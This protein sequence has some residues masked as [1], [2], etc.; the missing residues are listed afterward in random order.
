MS[1]FSL[2]VAMLLV[3]VPLSGKGNEPIAIQPGER[4]NYRV[5]W[6]I[7]FHAGEITIIA[8]PETNDNRPSTAVTST[9]STRGVLRR[10][11]RFEAQADA[12]FDNETGKMLVYTEKS[13]G[14]RKTTNY[15]IEFDYP[16]HVARYTDFVQSENSSAI[17]LPAEAPYDLIMALISTRGWNLKPG[18]AR[19]VN[20]LFGKDLYELTVH[21]LRYEDLTTALGTYHT[22]VYEPRM[23]KTPPKGMFKRGSAV[24][25]WISQ[26]GE[27]RLPVKFEVEFSFGA[28][29]A[30][31]AEYDPPGG[32]KKGAASDTKA[33]NN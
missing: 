11:F 25:V 33:E 4:L 7:F 18:E 31:L 26:D 21:A 14:G 16:Q 5:A 12:I 9:T 22:I 2:L 6:G 24:H 23:E 30:T 3:L 13:A 29:V 8:R 32:P 1:R 27:Q 10:L 19:D 20:V 15:S 28:G 17:N